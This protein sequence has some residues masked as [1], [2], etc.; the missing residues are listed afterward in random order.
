MAGE[1]WPEK[2]TVPAG[3]Q[4]NCSAQDFASSYK[5]I[6]A[7]LT[8]RGRSTVQVSYAQTEGQRGKGGKGK[9]GSKG[10]KGQRGEGRRGVKGQRGQRN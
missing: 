3:L 9:E 7:A 4:C 8:R 5:H 2:I 1:T 10:E 6:Q